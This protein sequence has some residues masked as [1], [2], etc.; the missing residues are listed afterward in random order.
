VPR[1]IPRLRGRQTPNVKN[2]KKLNIKQL[3]RKV[4]SRRA[5][6]AAAIPVAILAGGAMVMGGSSAAFSGK[7]AIPD[8]SWKAATLTLSSSTTSALFNATMKPGEVKNRCITI[9]S[10]ADVNVDLKLYAVG[11]G[12]SAMTDNLD[13]YIAPVSGGTDNG[14]DC[15]GYTETATALHS[16]TMSRLITDHSGWS[17]GL[18]GGALSSGQSKQ[19]LIKTTL[20]ASAPNTLQG[21]AT[22][23]SFVFEIQ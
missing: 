4:F 5:F 19:F 9:T 13:V 12:A 3:S 1:R 8:S 10:G 23:T 14:T 15:S 6:K 7:S 11:P 21:S 17:T 2:G 18:D 22:N 20:K 16:D